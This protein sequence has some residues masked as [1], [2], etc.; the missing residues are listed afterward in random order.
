V[1]PAGA[2]IEFEIEMLDSGEIKVAISVPCIGFTSSRKN[3]Y[4]RQEGQLDFAADSER[5]MEEAERL[6]DRADDMSL[7]VNDPKLEQARQ[8]LD[9]AH[10]LSSGVADA[11]KAQEAHEK[12]HEAK[13]LISEVRKEHAK[14]FHQMELDNVISFF[15]QEIRQ[16]ARPS[17][18]ETFENLTK[19]AQRAIDRKDKDFIR[20]L[21]ELKGKNFEILWRQDWFVVKCFNQLAA[22]PHTF[23]DR[24]RFNE[25][26]EIGTRFKN[27][28]ETENLRSVVAHLWMIQFDRFHDQYDTFAVNIIR[29]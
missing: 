17:E 16:L 25:L 15:Q 4:S 5:I 21:D 28:D 24:R 11:E 6:R 22:S 27:S 1:I 9:F 3:F 18:I 7:I 2:D 14:E 23:I 26:V 8:K 19:T 13:K 10:S 12:N 29:G 20:F